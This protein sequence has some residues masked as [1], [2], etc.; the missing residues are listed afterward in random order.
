MQRTL[1]PLDRGVLIVMA[2]PLDRYQGIAEYCEAAQ[3]IKRKSRRARFFLAST[4]GEAASPIVV[5]ELKRYREAVQ[6]IGPVDDAAPVIARCHLVV[7]PSYGNGAPR[8]LYQ[9]L[10]AGRPIVTTDTRSCRDFVQQG[11]NGY[12]VAVCD[13][14]SLARAITQIL[15]RPD[16]IASMSQESRRLALRFYDA[17]SVNALILETLGLLK[18]IA[19]PGRAGTLA[20]F[21][22]AA[23]YPR[24]RV[25]I[26]VLVPTGEMD[27]RLRA[28]EKIEMRS[29]RISYE[30]HS[31]EGWNPFIVLEQ[32]ISMGPR[33][34][35][36]DGAARISSVSTGLAIYSHAPSRE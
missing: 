28:C 35:G 7:A 31:H 1:P 25:P 16:L 20:E 5:S 13:T 10:A 27:S 6:Y 36:D 29:Q 34:R 32:A 24:M 26:Q 4:P 11:V 23:S 21:W 8:S 22:A 33:L 18:R 30:R 14:G 12:R 9:A 3:A 15:Q 19:V 2:A 17:N